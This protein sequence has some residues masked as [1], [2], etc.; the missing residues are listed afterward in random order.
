MRDKYTFFARNVFSL[1]QGEIWSSNTNKN[2][3]FLYSAYFIYLIPTRTE[4]FNSRELNLNLKFSGN[5]L[6]EYSIFEY[7]LYQ[8]VADSFEWRCFKFL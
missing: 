1:Q 8:L 7:H 4:S 3:L 6:C 5:K 2:K